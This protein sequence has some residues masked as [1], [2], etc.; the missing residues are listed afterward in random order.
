MYTMHARLAEVSGAL[1]RSFEPSHERKMI[2]R[3]G[4][5]LKYSK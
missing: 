4:T 5:S 2:L 1:G 3:L